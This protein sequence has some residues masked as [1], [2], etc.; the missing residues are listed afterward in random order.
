MKE[1]ASITFTINI[2]PIV[3]DKYPNTTFSVLFAKVMGDV[4]SGLK[5]LHRKQPG[6]YS[7][8]Q[9]QILIRK[10][11]TRLFYFG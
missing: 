2:N 7:K 10:S 5:I 9:I 11:I 4:E 3:W 8:S 1:A 6:N